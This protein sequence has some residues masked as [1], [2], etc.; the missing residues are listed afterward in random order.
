MNVLAILKDF[1]FR[2]KSIFEN[3]TT[4]MSKRFLNWL[5]LTI[6]T[7][8]LIPGKVNFTRLSRYGSRT[9]KTFASNFKGSVDW[10]KVNMGIARESVGDG[11]DIAIAI[12][13]S[14]I[15]KA[16]RLTYGIG[17][18]WSG[19]AQR[20]KRG[21]E[22][23]AIGAISLSKHTCVMLG[24]VQSPDFRTLES[25]KDMSML[26]WYISLVRSKAVEL[27]S[28]T[29]ILVADAFFSKYEF[30]NEMVAMGFRFVGRLRS[31]SY[32]R[33]LAIPDPSAP[34]RRGRRKKYG[35]KVDFSS[36]DMSVFTSFIY[37]DS[38][39][40]RTECHTAVVHSRAL[41]RDIRI[42]VCP[43]ENGESLVYFSTDTGM[44]PERIIG[45]YRTRFQIEFGIRDAKQFTGLQSQQT[46]DKERLDFAFNLS[47]TTLNVCKEVIRKDYPD[48]SLAQF[49]RLMFESYLAS[50]V[51]STYGKSPHLK[52]I[53]KINQRLAQLAA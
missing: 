32:L 21:L 18:F 30:I 1:T 35:E 40:I 50:T 47:F 29:D 9:A 39:G 45:F 17:H 44:A 27:L 36:L 43:V 14:F 16:G 3:T 34:P 2:C 37:E 23:M 15:S 49:K 5:I 24:A 25:E 48:L 22:I 7:I 46:R 28:L 33:Y 38:K 52:I 13:P 42:V 41:K 51:I 10:M 11:D 6:R 12:D 53:Q 4:K 26:D 20:V 31:N 8:A 19:M